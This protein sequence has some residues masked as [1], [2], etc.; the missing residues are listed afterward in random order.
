MDTKEWTELLAMLS[1]PARLRVLRALEAH[2]LAVG[3]IARALQMPQS[4]ASRHI[5]PLFDAQFVARRMEGT[6][7]GTRKNLVTLVTRQT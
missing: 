7:S 4:T 5:K 1:D 6:T 3:E 2:E